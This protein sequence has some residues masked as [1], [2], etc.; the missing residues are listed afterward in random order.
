M[1]TTRASATEPPA[2]VG[3][4]RTGD[5]TDGNVVDDSRTR[6]YVF[7]MLPLLALLFGCPASNPDPEDTSDDTDPD[8]ED[9]LPDVTITF[10]TL[11][12][13][14]NES[15]LATV[16]DVVRSVEGESF[17]LFNEV[18]SQSWL[19]TLADAADDGATYGT[20]F[21]TE[22]YDIR[23]G[24]AWDEAVFEVL[25]TYELDDVNVGGTVRPS[26]VAHVRVRAN[27]TE[28]LVVANHFWRSDWAKRQEQARILNEWGAAQTLPVLTMGDF[29]L[30]WDVEG[31]DT[32]HDEGYDALTANGVWSWVRPEELVPTQCSSFQSVL[33]FGFVGGAAQQWAASSE[34][35]RTESS[36]CHNEDNPDHR[37][38]R[39]TLTIPAL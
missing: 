1:R 6:S 37:P 29:N 39:V 8:T 4:P 34:I 27:G 26:L 5:A 28:L 7:G 21:G 33:D 24:L 32:D 31:G 18:Q 23:L 13:E 17:W 30:D 16:S 20:A 35:L 10:V 2:A 11:N 14:S 22:G 36:Y 15:E 25:D 38:L 19:T 12:T 3:I 9:P